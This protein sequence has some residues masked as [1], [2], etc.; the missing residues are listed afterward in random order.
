MA[1]IKATFY[2]AHKV[3][4]NQIKEVGLYAFEWLNAIPKVDYSIKYVHKFYHKTTYMACY[5]EIVTPINRQNKWPRTA[6]PEILPPSF[7]RGIGR[8]KKL[9]KRELDEASQ[10]R[11]K[12]TNTIHKCKTCL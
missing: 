11:W 2:E 8:P 9:R 4:I 7:K 1:A 12:R 3:K 10:T 6:D 5:N